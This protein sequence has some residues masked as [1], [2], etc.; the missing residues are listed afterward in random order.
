MLGTIAWSGSD[1]TNQTQAAEIRVLV[2]GT[3]G[4]DKMPGILAFATTAP[5][6]GSPAERMTI[7]SSGRVGIGTSNP[8]C[9]LDVA[10]P[11]R[12]GAANTSSAYLEVGAGATGD[13]TSLIDLVG[14]TTY[15]DFGLRLIRNGG[16]NADSEIR[17]RGT[18]DLI[19]NSQELGAVSFKT[20]N[21]EHVRIDSDG[22]LLVGTSSA[23]AVNGLTAG[24][25]LHSLGASNGASASIA[26]FA[27]DFS[28][29]KLNFGKSRSGTLS[30]GGI[31]QNDDALG[32]IIFC[33]D[34]GT[35]IA[36]QAAQIL[37][38]VDG[39]PGA[40]SMPGRLTFFTTA[41]GASVPTE[42][43][44][45]ASTGAIGLGGAHY[46][47]SGQVLTS[48]GPGSAPSWQNAA[49]GVPS[50]AVQ[51]FALK[52]APS[53]WI[54]ADGTA[55]SRTTYAALFAAIHTTFGVGNGSTTFNLPDLRGEFLLG[56][57]HTP[58]P[59]THSRNIALLACIK[60]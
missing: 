23:V 40:N 52:S 28:G 11:C 58:D 12:V 47:S 41:A 53:G 4:A 54:K 37:G 56:S 24:F 29:P 27:N 10:G 1:G 16:A 46:G 59:H 19:L 33:G 60:L 5:G 35:D 7:K 6:T 2:D 55:I 25:E 9:T 45:I 32:E 18:G 42:R 57:A 34:D 26:R 14:D 44:R 8:A 21:T 17:H 50:G 15:S 43:M 13:R 22:R 36:S 48:K 20:N 31:V 51:Y 30:H 49:V 3:P 38:V 39:I